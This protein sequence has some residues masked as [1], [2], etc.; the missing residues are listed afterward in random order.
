MKENDS[1][2][3]TRRNVVESRSNQKKTI[4]RGSNDLQYSMQN[5]AIFYWK[6]IFGPFSS[7]KFDWIFSWIMRKNLFSIKEYWNLGKFWV[8]VSFFDFFRHVVRI[9][10]FRAICFRFIAP[11]DCWLSNYIAYLCR[12]GGIIKETPRFFF[13]FSHRFDEEN[14]AN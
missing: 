2:L 6:T 13:Q 12:G 1:R 5:N 4:V 3:I 7:R 11:N 9:L 8:N 10:E 14:I